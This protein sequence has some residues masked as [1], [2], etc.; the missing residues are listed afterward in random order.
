MAKNLTAAKQL[1]DKF[2]AE[3]KSACV[4]LEDELE[5]PGTGTPNQRR[6][7]VKMGLVEDTHEKCLTALSQVWNLEKTSPTEETKRNWVNTNLR[8]PKNA[9]VN[10]AQELLITLEV[11]ES[12]AE[13]AKAAATDDK[14]KAKVEMVSFEAELKAELEGLIQVVGETNIWLKDSHNALTK[15]ADTIHERLTKQHMVMGNIQILGNV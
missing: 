8:K 1:R 14:R 5:P 9:V 2:W 11:S 4:D 3:F 13:K 15:N 10:K 12:P 6:I 7:K